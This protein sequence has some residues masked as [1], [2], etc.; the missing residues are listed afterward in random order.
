MM[1][2]PAIIVL[3][4]IF[5]IDSFSSEKRDLLT[6]HYSRK[7]VNSVLLKNHSWTDFPSYY[8]KSVWPR[9]PEG[10]RT[11]TIKEAEKYLH[12]NW[13][14]TTSTMYLELTKTGNRSIVDSVDSRLQ[15]ALRS[16][17]LAELIEGK[18]RFI[19]DIIIGVFA[20]CEQTYWEASAYF[21]LYGFD[22]SEGTINKP[23]TVLPDRD[24]PNFDLMVSEMAADLAWIYFYFHKEFDTVS[25]VISKRLKNELRDKVLNPYYKRFDLGWITGWGEGD[26]FQLSKNQGNTKKHFI[27]GNDIRMIRPGN[28]E[29]SGEGLILNMLFYPSFLFASIEDKILNDEISRIVFDLKSNSLPKMCCLNCPKQNCRKI[30][31]DELKLR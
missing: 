16:L 27:I 26:W 8:N 2:S 17:V 29:L 31:W 25:P 28:L 19:D 3:L 14:A 4:L 13:P 9:V 20:V 22:H 5:T 1:K 10:I 15:D 24:D 30:N 23:F 18:K 11:K 6:D 7:Y 12:Y 21:Y